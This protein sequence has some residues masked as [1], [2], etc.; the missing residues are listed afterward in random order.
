MAADDARMTRA[1][2]SL[3]FTHTAPRTHGCP[4]AWAQPNAAAAGVITK[5][6]ATTT[7]IVAFLAAGE[8]WPD[9]GLRPAVEDLSFSG[10]P[11]S[12][13]CPRGSAGPDDDSD[14]QQRDGHAYL[15]WAGGVDAQQ[16]RPAPE[17]AVG[18]VA[19]ECGC[20]DVQDG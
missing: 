6:L 4:R 15:C 7:G 16:P 20:G 3:H 12:E 13:L 1:S 18:P 9:E 2:G 8:R 19:E 14:D 10:A 17:G 11:A 5:R